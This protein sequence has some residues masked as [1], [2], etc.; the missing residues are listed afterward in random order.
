MNIEHFIQYFLSVKKWLV[1][2]LGAEIAE[3][4]FKT[5]RDYYK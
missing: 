4:S 3:S 2:P 5:I 1:E